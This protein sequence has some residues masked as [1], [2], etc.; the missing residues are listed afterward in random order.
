MIAELASEA[1]SHWP[2]IS[3]AP[4]L[5]THRENAVFRVETALGP[6]ALRLHRVGYHS[7]AALTSELDWMAML[8]TR[9]M[10]VPR[11]IVTREGRHLARLTGGRRASLLSWLPGAPLGKTREP[12]A[13]HGSARTALFRALGHQMAQMHDLSDTWTMPPQFQRPRWDLEGLVGDAPFWGPFWTIKASADDRALLTSTRNHCRAALSGTNADF[14]LIHADL[15]RE[16]VLVDGKMLHFIDFDDCGF[17]Y[18]LFDLATTILKN[19]DEPDA[20]DLEAALLDGYCTLRQLDLS[21]LPVFI[22][23]RALSYIGWAQSRPLDLGI[24]DRAARFLQIAKTVIAT[25]LG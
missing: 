11:P 16:N 5:V 13:Q 20:S 9:G 4:V 10:H 22:T 25:R 17:G 21:L 19:I 8:S 14:G 2:F 1:A 7:D 24:E 18:R 23:L 3:G 6:H 12:L 15:V